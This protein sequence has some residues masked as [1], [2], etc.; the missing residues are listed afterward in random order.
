MKFAFWFRLLVVVLLLRVTT[1]FG[2]TLVEITAETGTV[3]FTATNSLTVV[4]PGGYTVTVSMGAD[5]ALTIQT[6]STN[7]GPL[8]L[9]FGTLNGKP[10]T[11]SIAPGSS[12]TIGGSLTNGRLDSVNMTVA[13]GGLTLNGKTI[14]AGSAINSADLSKEF[15]VIPG[16]KS[17]ISQ[18][19][20]TTLSQPALFG[21][22]GALAVGLAASISDRNKGQP[23]N[24]TGTTGTR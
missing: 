22:F 16:A 11:G 10:I 1:A 8:Q 17:A 7:P 2:A 14:P 13:K 9:D 15:V 12:T 23:L 6:P 3:M 19:G 20:V 4:I 21:I 18:S 5:G 24:A